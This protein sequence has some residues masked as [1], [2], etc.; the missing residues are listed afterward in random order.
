M[1]L[2]QNR[3]LNKFNL[4]KKIRKIDKIKVDNKTFLQEWSQARQLGLPKYIVMANS[5]Q[6]MD[7]YLLLRLK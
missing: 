5:D 4:E 3:K 7:H 6:I 1:W 2:Q